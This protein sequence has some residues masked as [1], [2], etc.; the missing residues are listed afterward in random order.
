MLT[1][2]SILLIT[3]MGLFGYIND[4]V[5]RRSKEIAIRKVNGAEAYDILSLLSKGMARIAVPAVIIGVICSY[6]IGK[7]WLLQFERFRMELSIPLFLLVAI[8][9]LF[10]IFG[11]V[12][13]KSWHIANDDPV[14]SI[15]NE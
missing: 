10:L 7:E 15:K 9:I 14:N 2:A 11:T 4:E 8:A 13:L 1:F 6:F 12:I 3:L 5:R